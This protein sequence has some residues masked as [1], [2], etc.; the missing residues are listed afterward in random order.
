M[1]SVHH[2]DCTDYLGG[3]YKVNRKQRMIAAYRS[4]ASKAFD[5]QLEYST[6]Y[7]LAALVL[8]MD[9]AHAKVNHEKWFN[10]F[11][12]IYPELLKDPLPYIKKAED[13]AGMDIEIHW[14]E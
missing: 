7:V 10:A 3:G 14:T 13:I 2:T 1:D 4:I 6:T 11:A 5:A 9:K 8:A 12:E